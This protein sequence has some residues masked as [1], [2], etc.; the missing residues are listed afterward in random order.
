LPLL[1]YLK[2][3][4]RMETTFDFDIFFTQYA[5]TENEYEKAKMLVEFNR[6]YDSLP[7]NEKE[8]VKAKQVIKAKALIEQT[9]ELLG[10]KA[11]A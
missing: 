8:V 6:L 9:N 5:A 7:E 2:K 4:N 1:F 10:E 3:N 11:I